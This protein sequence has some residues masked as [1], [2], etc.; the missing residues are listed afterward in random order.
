MEEMFHI[1]IARIRM[2]WEYRLNK[3]EKFSNRL[4]LAIA[5]KWAKRTG[6]LVL[7]KPVMFDGVHDVDVVMEKSRDLY[8]L[9]GSNVY[10]I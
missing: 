4:K 5:K 9:P 7:I 6:K 10:K 1:M 8:F 3:R 2:L